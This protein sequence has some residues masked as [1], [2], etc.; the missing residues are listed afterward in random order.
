MNKLHPPAA[1]KGEGRER[2]PVEREEQECVLDGTALFV[3]PMSCD[4]TPPVGVE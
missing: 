4:I 2:E 3:Q 1:W